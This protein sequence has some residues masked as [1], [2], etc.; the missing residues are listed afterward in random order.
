MVRA[1]ERKTSYTLARRYL[2][3]ATLLTSQQILP[4]IIQL[5]NP[6]EGKEMREWKWVRCVRIS[7]FHSENDMDPDADRM[8]DTEC[9][10]DAECMDRMNEA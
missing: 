4:K 1:G 9:M 8:D 7:R 3:L 5:H 6:G 2:T 10:D